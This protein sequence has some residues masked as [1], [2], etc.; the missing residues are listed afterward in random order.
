MR[1][2]KPYCRQRLGAVSLRDQPLQSARAKGTEVTAEE[3]AG[4]VTTAAAMPTLSGGRKRGWD[5]DNSVPGHLPLESNSALLC[6]RITCTLIQPI[7]IQ[8]PS[9]S[10]GEEPSLFQVS[11]LPLPTFT[12]GHRCLHPN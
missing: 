12:V 9:L 7:L 11:S 8:D 6:V 2:K 10:S 3:G 1:N 4:L 5:S